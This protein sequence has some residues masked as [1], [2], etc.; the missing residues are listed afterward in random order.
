MVEGRLLGVV[1]AHHAGWHFVAADPVVGDL[2]G[3]V[4]R[5][6]DEA[7]RIAGLVLARARALPPTLPVLRQPPMLRVVD[8]DSA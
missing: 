4:F 2:H 5:D 1:M 7:R 6:E 3:Q 8:E